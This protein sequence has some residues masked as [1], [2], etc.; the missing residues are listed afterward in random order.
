MIRT[1]VLFAF[2]AAALAFSARDVASHEASAHKNATTEAPGEMVELSIPV[3]LD[4]AA[5]V[6]EVARGVRVRLSLEGAGDH[7]LH[8]HGFDI[9]VAAKAGAPAVFEFD[10]LHSGRFA[11]VA[12]GV[13]D[14]L[15]RGEKPVAYIE[16]REQ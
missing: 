7:E 2:C 14:L 13:E 8:L 9:T 1:H 11:I 3:D 10:A 12:H 5:P 6:V 16:V 15:G 4:T